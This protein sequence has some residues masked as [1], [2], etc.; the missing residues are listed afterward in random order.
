[1]TASEQTATAHPQ[2][3][4]ADDS[5]GRMP[6]L[7]TRTLGELTITYVPDAGVHMI[8]TRVYPA[9]ADEDWAGHVPHITDAGHLAM[10]C[11]ALLVERDGKRLLLDAGHGRISGEDIEHFQH[12]FDHVQDLPGHLRDLGVDPATL[13]TVAFTHLHDDHT[14]WAR[15]DAVDDPRSL[16]PHARWLVGEGELEGLDPAA[17]ARLAG[18]SERATAVA[19]GTEIAEGIR[20]WALPGHTTGHTA[21]VLDTGDGRRV[22]AFGDAMHSPVQV[23]HPDWE[24]VLDHD[25]AQAERSRRELVE[26][27][28]K[29][30]VY[31][32]GV[33][34]AD[35]QL[36]TVDD[37]GRWR[38]WDDNKDKR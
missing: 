18:Q 27:M 5:G 17:G 32:I 3:D 26:F 29:D 35:Q 33:H 31:G 16:F 10:G 20:G 37:T 28:A 11:G 15:P 23:Q 24:V 2:H 19:D 36:G 14:G 1:M 4:P 12:G 6:Q 13:D 38:P 34:F 9:S 8:P 25:R 21:W 30:E 7:W 22:V